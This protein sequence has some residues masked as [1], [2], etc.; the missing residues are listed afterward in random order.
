M[1]RAFSSRSLRELSKLPQIP[2]SIHQSLWGFAAASRLAG[3]KLQCP[4]NSGSGQL[5]QKPVIRAFASLNATLCCRLPAAAQTFIVGVPFYDVSFRAFTASP[6]VLKGTP[7]AQPFDN[8]S[9]A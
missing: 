6:T 4:K 8:R 5:I 2:A 9:I 7:T 3:G 1:L